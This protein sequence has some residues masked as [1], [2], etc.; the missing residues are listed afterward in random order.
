MRVN[1]RA[2]GP[3]FL[4]VFG[5]VG[6]VFGGIGAFIALNTLREQARDVRTTGTIVD[7][8]PSSNGDG[9]RMYRPVFRFSVDGQ[10]Y[11][12]ESGMA[13]NPPQYELEQRVSVRY[14]PANPSEASLDNAFENWFLPGIFCFFGVVFGGI[15]L[16]VT[17]LALRSKLLR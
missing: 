13:S 9:G 16:A 12:I 10:I 14:N 5:L 11:E 6:L 7:M 8:V 4:L 15:A 1:N 17:G 3:L 2:P